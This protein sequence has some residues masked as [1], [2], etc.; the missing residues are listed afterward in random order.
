[1]NNLRLLSLFS[2][3]LLVLGLTVTACGQSRGSGGNGDDDDDTSN[4]DDVSDDDDDD[5]DDATGDDDD[6]TGD[7][8]DA[9]GN[10][11]PCADGED[12]SAYECDPLTQLPCETAA[13]EACDVAFDQSIGGLGGFSCYPAPNDAMI[14]EACDASAGPWCA[15]GGT[16]VATD[17]SGTAFICAKFCCS[18][19]QC[20]EGQSCVVDGSYAPAASD[21]G[22]CR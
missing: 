8:D 16:C 22:V 13:G 6:A 1:M 5:D 11:T 20:D 15:A 9:V 4:D 17:E 2:I 19:S 10:S 18:D 7:D 3:L 12:F 14:G 21:M